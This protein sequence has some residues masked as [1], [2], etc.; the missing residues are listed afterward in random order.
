MY[1]LGHDTEIS[2]WFLLRVFTVYAR[3]SV[4]G[5][6]TDCICSVYCETVLK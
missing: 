1:V 4:V 2:V 6:L 5:H 3:V